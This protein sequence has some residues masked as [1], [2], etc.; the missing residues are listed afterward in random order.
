MPG[1]DLHQKLYPHLFG[2]VVEDKAA[3]HP[4]TLKIRRIL[5]KYAKKRA[6]AKAKK[7]AKNEPRK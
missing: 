5:A 7:E 6:K 3:G 1:E 2:G 4:L